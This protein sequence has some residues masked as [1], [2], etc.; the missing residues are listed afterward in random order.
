M[1]MFLC[2]PQWEPVD[3]ADRS[4][5]SLTA[6]WSD[7][8]HCQTWNREDL[9]PCWQQCGTQRHTR[10]RGRDARS[11]LSSP[12]ANAPRVCRSSAGS[13][14]APE[15]EAPSCVVGCECAHCRARPARGCAAVGAGGRCEMGARLPPGDN[16]KQADAVRAGSLEPLFAGAVLAQDVGGGL[17]QGAPSAVKCTPS[18]KR[19]N[20]RTADC[21][22][23]RKLWRHS[24]RV[25]WE[26]RN[27]KCS[28]EHP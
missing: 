1:S 2:N 6:T 3:Q 9:R 12:A 27:S 24:A 16:P 11:E 19:S 21:R 10:S 7:R 5:C 14:R 17:N 20:S 15:P 23:W 4:G 22:D 13:R 25:R 26:F 8:R 28:H 18:G